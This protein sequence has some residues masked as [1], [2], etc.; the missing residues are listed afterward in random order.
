MSIQ[1]LATSS[2]LVALCE[3]A[4]IR[5]CPWQSF[6]VG[7]GDLLIAGK[8]SSCPQKHKPI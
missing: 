6:D 7:N 5:C 1:I 4:T 2:T 8:F 3:Q